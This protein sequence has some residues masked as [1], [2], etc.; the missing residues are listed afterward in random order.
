MAGTNA[1]EIFNVSTDESGSLSA[2]IRGEKEQI[3][4][5]RFLPSLFPHSTLRG[6]VWSRVL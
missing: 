5:L 3:S 1:H 4:L 2:F 6:T